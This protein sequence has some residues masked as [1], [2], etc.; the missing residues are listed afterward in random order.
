MGVDSE[1]DSIVKAY[2]NWIGLSIKEYRIDS[3]RIGAT[4]HI[5]ANCWQPFVGDAGVS[6]IGGYT[7][8]GS[9]TKGPLDSIVT[10]SMQLDAFTI[11]SPRS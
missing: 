2:H 8:T 3:L 6:C 11:L 7:P 5:R 1:T 4:Q 10:F 9:K